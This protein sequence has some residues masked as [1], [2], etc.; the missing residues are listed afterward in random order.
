VIP[1]CAAVN[2]TMVAIAEKANIAITVQTSA[3]LYLGLFID[4]LSFLSGYF[5][6]DIRANMRLNQYKFCLNQRTTFGAEK[7]A[8]Q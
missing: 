2:G 5:S 4:I 1:V 7:R 8:V 6:L 3:R